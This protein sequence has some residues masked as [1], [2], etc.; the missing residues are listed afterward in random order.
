MRI[1]SVGV[2]GADTVVNT[3]PIFTV[4]G[5]VGFIVRLGEHK[6]VSSHRHVCLGQDIGVEEVLGHVSSEMAH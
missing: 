4:V 3:V 6:T 2:T 1:Q 5:A